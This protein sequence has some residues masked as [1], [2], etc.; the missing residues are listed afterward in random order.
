[1][2]NLPLLWHSYPIGREIAL[3]S[4]HMEFLTEQPKSMK[5][6]HFTD[7]ITGSRRLSVLSMVKQPE[8]TRSFQLPNSEFCPLHYNFL[9]SQ[10]WTLKATKV[11]KLAFKE[12]DTSV[13]AKALNSSTNV[14]LQTRGVNICTFPSLL[15]NHCLLPTPSHLSR[16]TPDQSPELHF[17]FFSNHFPKGLQRI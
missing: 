14:S 9:L 15:P 17:C 8:Q 1:M 6:P 7:R 4:G 10:E 16:L 13:E 5:A 11:Q 3:I 2:W 12:K